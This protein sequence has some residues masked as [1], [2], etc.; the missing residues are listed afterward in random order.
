VRP[1]LPALGGW[2]YVRF[3]QGTAR[4]PDYRRDKL[5]RWASRIAA[6]DAEEAFIYFNN[7]QTGAAIRDARTMIGLLGERG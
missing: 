5:R 7:D 6:A 2:L 1:T 4:G 3:H